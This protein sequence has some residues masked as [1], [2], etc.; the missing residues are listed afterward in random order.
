MQRKEATF[1]SLIV[2]F[3]YAYD[4]LPSVVGCHILGALRWRQFLSPLAPGYKP[5]AGVGPDV[6]V[7]LE[8][9]IVPGGGIYVL[10]LRRDWI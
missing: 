1:L 5:V 6:K 4:K 3:T 7:D 10:C 9:D 2:Q 8:F